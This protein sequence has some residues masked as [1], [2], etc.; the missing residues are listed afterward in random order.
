VLR[1]TERLRMQV[2]TKAVIEGGVRGLRV[3]RV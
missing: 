1:I 3:W 2:I